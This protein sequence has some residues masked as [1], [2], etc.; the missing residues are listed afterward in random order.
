MLEEALNIDTASDR[1]VPTIKVDHHTPRTPSDSG[2]SR[3]I[4]PA[5]TEAALD[6]WYPSP[7]TSAPLLPYYHAPTYLPEIVTEFNNVTLTPLDEGTVAEDSDDGGFEAQPW[8]DSIKSYAS[9]SYYPSSTSPL[10]AE[11]TAVDMFGYDAFFPPQPSHPYQTVGQ[12]YA[13]ASWSPLAQH[14]GPIGPE[15]GY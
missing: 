9:D 12:H 1:D 3:P 7:A 6:S 5:T 15:M 2:S 4:S 14:P 10:S 13:F 8:V 11:S